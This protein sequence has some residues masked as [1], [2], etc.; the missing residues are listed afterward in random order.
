MFNYSRIDAMARAGYRYAAGEE[1]VPRLI[2]QM[3]IDAFNAGISNYNV[4]HG[5][6]V[7]PLGWVGS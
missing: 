3:D 1:T 4:H 6:Q 7:P 5:T 2:D